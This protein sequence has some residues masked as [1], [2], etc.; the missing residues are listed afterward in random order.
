MNAT[1]TPKANRTLRIISKDVG[2]VVVEIR[3][4]RLEDTYEITPLPSDYGLAVT[5]AKL[6]GKARIGERYDVCV[7]HAGNVDGPNS[8]G[9]PAFCKSGSCRH[10]A[11]A[12]VLISRGVLS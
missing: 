6:T 7:G 2:R 5:F 8:C 11:A 1:C 4:G 12:G 3:D 9:C 10:L